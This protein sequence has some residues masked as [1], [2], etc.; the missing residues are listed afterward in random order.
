MNLPYKYIGF[1]IF[2]FVL[3]LPVPLIVSSIA[4]G[5]LLLNIILLIKNFFFGGD[6]WIYLC[7]IFFLLNPLRSMV[8]ALN[9][10][11]DNPFTFFFGNGIGSF[12]IL[13]PGNDA[14]EYPHYVFIEVLFEL[15]IVGL[16]FIFTISL[17]GKNHR[18]FISPYPFFFLN[19]MKSHGLTSLRLLFMSIGFLAFYE[20]DKLNGFR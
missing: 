16:A 7:L 2:S 4:T 9:H 8:F 18:F 5:I 14:Y 10:S 6:F 15:G 3:P 19:A 1:Y 20:K 13:Y 11:N 12:G 17:L